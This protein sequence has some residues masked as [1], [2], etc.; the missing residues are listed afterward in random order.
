MI[1]M[2]EEFVCNAVLVCWMR[3][4]KKPQRLHNG[5]IVVHAAVVADFKGKELARFKFSL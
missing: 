3:L 1:H 2:M 4:E 5:E